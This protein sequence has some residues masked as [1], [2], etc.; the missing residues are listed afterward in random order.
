MNTGMAIV[1]TGSAVK[2]VFSIL[3]HSVCTFLTNLLINMYPALTYSVTCYMEISGSEFQDNQ[4]IIAGFICLRP[5][6]VE[7]LEVSA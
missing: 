1:N 5:D 3:K 7:V 4:T 6:G 2:L